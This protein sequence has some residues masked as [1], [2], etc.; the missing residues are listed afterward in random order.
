MA[1]G[2]A[3]PPAAPAGATGRRGG[4]ARRSSSAS[5][6]S[7]GAATTRPRSTT[8]SGRSPRRWPRRPGVARLGADQV[9]EVAFRR[10]RIGS[11][12]YDEDEVDAFLDLLE[13][14]AALAGHPGRAARPGRRRSRR[15]PGARAV[16]VGRRRGA[17]R[18]RP[19]AGRRAARPGH[20]PDRLPAARRRGRLRRAGPRDRAAVRSGR[21]SG[22]GWPRCD[23]WP[24]WRA[25]TASPAGTGTSWCWSTRRRPTDPG[26]WT[27]QRLT[28][29]RGDPSAVWAPM[30]IFRRG[31]AQLLP[32]GLLPLLD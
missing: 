12:G 28:S 16:Q 11:R 31:E 18:P 8:S 14:R 3:G 27:Q 26:L 1:F 30:D 5:R 25:S 2:Q 13:A 6:R 23:R 15:A 20:R 29:R 7:A 22:S 24:R 9:H 10:P 4:R 19:A 17:G 21:T 32:D